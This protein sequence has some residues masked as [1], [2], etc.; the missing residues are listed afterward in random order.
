[1]DVLV[2]GISELHID[3]LKLKN[4]N[5]KGEE[6]ARSLKNMHTQAKEIDLS[7]NQIGPHINFL[8]EMIID[9]NSQLR[10]LMLDKVNLSDKG[11]ID[12]L[13][14]VENSQNIQC[15]G[16][17]ENKLNDTIGDSLAKLV[18][19]NKNVQELYLSWNNLS[20]I[21]GE[22]LFRALLK[23]DTLQV[24]DLGWNSLG[25][26]MKVMKRNAVQLVDILSGCLASNKSLLHLNL[27]NNGFS[28]EE[29]QKLGE[30]NTR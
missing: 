1:M 14:W 9:S 22:Q 15:L 13:G 17:S 11:A 23:N 4:N 8:R 29:S 19:N 21:A 26:N 12:L 10:K 2:G 25:S 7:M 27:C 5:L 30:V 28:F 20:S 6:I 16:I 24:L 18:T 3:T